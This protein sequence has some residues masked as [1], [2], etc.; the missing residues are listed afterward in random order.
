V[1]AFLTQPG[2]VVLEGIG[3]RDAPAGMSSFEFESRPGP[4]RV[5]LVRTTAGSLRQVNRDHTALSFEAPEWITDRPWRQD[6]AIRGFSSE[7]ARHWKKWFPGVEPHFL[8]E[9]GDADGNGLPNWFERYY[10]G[11][12]CGLDP[13]ADPDRDGNSNRQEFLDGTD[14]L[15]P[16]VAYPA[17]FRWNPAA[18]FKADNET[19]PV[20][21]AKGMPVWEYEFAPSGGAATFA[22]ARLLVPQIPAWLER[23]DSWHFGVGLPKD[24]SLSYFGEG[25]SHSSTVWNSPVSGRVRVSVDAAT[26]ESVAPVRLTLARVGADAPLWQCDYGP[27]EKTPG[28]TKEIKVSRG[29]RLRLSA[30]GPPAA[31]AW[32][33]RLRWS[34]TPLTE[35]AMLQ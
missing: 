18:D 3:E 30:T 33:V 25:D 12:W 2:R 13:H 21:D 5:S 20:L 17:G 9:Y 15:N 4:V 19:Y 26:D 35:S 23:S 29:D 27:R 11:Q 28:C 31:P 8:S 22:P 6:F 10:F 16:P 1:R 14:P 24:G 34:I 7:E 32:R